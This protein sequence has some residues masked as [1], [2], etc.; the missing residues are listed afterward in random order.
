MRGLII[1]R[2]FLDLILSGKKQWE[3]RGS[4]A[5]YRGQI[6]LI[7]SGSGTVVGHCVLHDVVGPLTLNDLRAN[8]HRIGCKASDIT[9]KYYQ[10]TYAWVLHDAKRLPRP[11]PYSHPPGAVI[12]VRLPPAI[13]SKLK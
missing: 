6:A 2:Q 4:R 11:I 8:A 1:R 13:K 3:I 5:H 9:V 12:W 10:K 7:E